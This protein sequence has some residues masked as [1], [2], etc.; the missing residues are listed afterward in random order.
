MG[1]LAQRDLRNLL[2]CL[3]DIYAVRSLSAFRTEVTSTLRQVVPADH[4]S[5][6][7][8]NP[9]RKLLVAQADPSDAINFPN[10]LEVFRQ[11]VSEHPLISHY[12][13]TRTGRALKISDFLT[14]GQFHRLALYNEFF[15]RANV[16][17]QIAVTL[18]APSPLVIGIAFNRSHTDFS[19]DERLCLNFLR[20]HLIQAYDNAEVIGQIAPEERLLEH[21]VSQAGLGVVVTREE[22]VRLV[23]PRAQR[24]L[25][26]YFGTPVRQMER[27][28]DTLRRWIRHH[29]VLSASQEHLHLTREPLRVQQNGKEL[30]VR[31][32]CEPDQTFLLLKEQITTVQSP[33]LEVFGL[34]RREA[35]VLAWVARGKTNDETA[36]IL[37][38]SPR[39]VAKHLEMTYPKLGVE[40]RT[41]AAARALEALSKGGPSVTP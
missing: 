33:A 20:P 17:H 19:E 25:A 41:S 14:Q 31:I 39:T 9:R 29:A 15:R 38:I 32:L 26:E 2:N 30:I 35:E 3:R 4:T 8:I 34:T 7:E 23:T 37:G 16:E 40:N 5:Y 22:K 11:H 6:N 1:R 36:T 18:P 27:L 10:S 28:P 13:R 12:A 21:V 24:W